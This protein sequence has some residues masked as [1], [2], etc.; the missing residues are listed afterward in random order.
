MN[1]VALVLFADAIRPREQIQ[2]VCRSFEIEEEQCFV[3][4]DTTT[5]ENPFAEVGNA[6]M[7]C[8]VNSYSSHC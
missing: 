6:L 4:R 3:A 5:A 7:V 1:L 2:D 8:C